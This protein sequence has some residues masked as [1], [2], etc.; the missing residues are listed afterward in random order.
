APK[1][2][3]ELFA[4][5]AK[6]AR[7][8]LTELNPWLEERRLG[9][10]EVVRWKARDGLEIEGLLVWPVGRKPD[11]EGPKVPLVVIVHGGPE[12]HYRNGWITRYSEPAQVLAGQGYAV[13][14]PNYRASTGRGVEFSML[15]HKDP[16]GKEFDDLVDGVDFLVAKGLVDSARVGVTGGSYGGYASGWCATKHTARF[17]A[18]VM[19]FGVANLLSMSGTS[20]IPEEHYLVHHRM[21][22]WENWQ[23]FL[24]RSPIYYAP[25]CKTPILILAGKADP[26]V[27]PSQSMELYRYLEAAGHKAARLV[28]YP[29]EGH[30]NARAASRLDYHLRLLQWFDH[31]LK[32][33]GGAPPPME[34]DYSF[35]VTGKN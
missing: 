32:S 26:R 17:A 5:N 19:G 35:M 2:G 4:W 14:L 23:L 16:A 12:A 3:N 29:G 7:T 21:H 8:R 31:Y 18:A 34:L 10:Q 25:Q 13:L 30:G 33:A 6:G 15:D 9:K 20:D 22:V 11:E 27:P 24:E 28:Q 1:W